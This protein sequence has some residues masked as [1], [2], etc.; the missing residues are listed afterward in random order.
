MLTAEVGS[1]NSYAV[2]G[3]M[4]RPSFSECHVT[5]AVK[6]V[7]QDFDLA[8]LRLGIYLED[9]EP[10]VQGHTQGKSLQ[11]VL[12]QQKFEDNLNI[13]QQGSD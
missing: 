6:N 2:S 12:S 1:Q 11:H 9:T 4:H 13:H 3:S 8:I 10:G 5:L 7:Y